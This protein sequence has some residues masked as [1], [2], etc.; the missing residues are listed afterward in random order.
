MPFMPEQADVLLRF[1]AAHD[2]FLR[3][4]GRIIYKSCG[5]VNID[6]KKKI[7]TRNSILIEKDDSS[8]YDAWNQAMVVLGDLKISDNDYVIW[9]G[10]DDVLKE[11]FVDA[12][13]KLVCRTLYFDFIYGDVVAS[14]RGSRRYLRSNFPSKLFGQKRRCFD[15]FHPGMLNRWGLIK[16]ERFDL[17]Y[18]LAADMDFYIGLTQKHN[19]VYKKIAKVQAFIGSEGISQ[20][21]QAKSIYLKELSQIEERRKVSIKTDRLRSSILIFLANFPEVYLFLKRLYWKVCH[22]N[23]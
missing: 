18:K 10:V 15:I 4:G 6:L 5:R 21:L 1:H 17:S 20:G 16:E 7:H 8:L 13:S 9:L 11:E 2:F 12:A 19:I 3:Q 14:F 22:K 23:L